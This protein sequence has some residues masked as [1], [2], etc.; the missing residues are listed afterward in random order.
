MWRYH[1]VINVD[2][3]KRQAFKK[4]TCR[5]KQYRAIQNISQTKNLLFKLAKL[6]PFLNFF[7]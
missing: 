4:N 7:V 6:K 5:F 2:N 3:K 1:F